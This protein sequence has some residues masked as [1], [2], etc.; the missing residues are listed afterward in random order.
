MTDKTKAL[1]F[2]T[3]SQSAKFARIIRCTTSDTSVV[4][5]FAIIQNVLRAIS[6]MILTRLLVPEAFGIAGIIGSITFTASM[7]SDLGFQAFVVRH[8]KGD[9][10]RFLDTVW[11]IALLRS[12]IL[13]VTLVALSG[14]ISSLLGKPEV[15]PMIE[16]AAISFIIEGVASLTLLTAVR[17]RLLLRLSVLELCVMIVQIVVS[18]ILAWLWRDVWAIL[19]AL[20]VSSSIKSLLSYMMFT[21]ARRRLAFD[22]VYAKDLWRFARYIAGSSMITLLI[23][24][25]DKLVLARVMPLDELGLYILAGNLASAPLAFVGPYTTRVLYPVYAEQWQ[26]QDANLRTQFYAKRWVPSCLYSLAT[27]G[28][29]GCAPFI[30]MLLYD[31]RY[32]A[33]GIYL[34][35]LAIAPFFALASASAGETLTATGYVATNFQTGIIKIVWLAVALPLAYLAT[36]TLGVVAVVGLLELPA[37]IFRWVQVRRIGLLHLPKELLLIGIGFLGI[38]LGALGSAVL[39]LLVH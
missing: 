31:P 17:K 13:A 37:L 14:P 18:V 30:V 28:L 21:D 11:T 16:F 8:E 24:Q 23:A 22:P 6:G 33:A 29:I 38:L 34:Q 2:D 27:G 7:L 9:S 1:S 20:L 32:A 25:S 36:G 3:M 39:S 15:A 12:A 35:L 26:N 10:R 19:V 4:V 5:S